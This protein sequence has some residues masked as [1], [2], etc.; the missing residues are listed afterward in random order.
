MHIIVEEKEII[1][2][3]R[4][5]VMNQGINTIGKELEVTLT[6]GRKDGHTATVVISNSTSAV[7]GTASTSEPDV[8]S[9]VEGNNTMEEPFEVTAKPK[10]K[11]RTKKQMAEARA[12][13]EAA[14]TDEVTADKETVNTDEDL[15]STPD[16]TDE[17][18]EDDTPAFM[19][20]TEEPVSKEP[21]LETAGTSEDDTESLFG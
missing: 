12:A 19:T 1:Q 18:T 7:L 14:K 6:A 9:F 11:R 2:A 21:E 20:D 10:K 16:V 5:Y 3:I 8:E 15:P 13:E 17:K 4:E